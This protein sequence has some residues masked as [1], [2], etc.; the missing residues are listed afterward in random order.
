MPYSNATLLCKLLHLPRKPLATLHVTRVETIGAMKP[1]AAGHL[2]AAGTQ[3]DHACM[4]TPI[5]IGQ[6]CM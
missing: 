3:A 4:Q 2:T 5:S 6:R 1:A